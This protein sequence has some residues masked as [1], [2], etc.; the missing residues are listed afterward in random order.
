MILNNEP[1]KFIDLIHKL[2]KNYD[3]IGI[4]LILNNKRNC[5]FT[6]AGCF[7]MG[8]NDEIIPLDGDSYSKNMDVWYWEEFSNPDENVENGLSIWVKS[9]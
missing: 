3:W 4:E 8:D 9:Y 1:I 6:F 5:E 7:K 2:N